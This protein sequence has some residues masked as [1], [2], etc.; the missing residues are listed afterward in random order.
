M[1]EALRIANMFSDASEFIWDLIKTNRD[2]HVAR[3]ACRSVGFCPHEQLDAASDR[4]LEGHRQDVLPI[5]V[6]ACQNP[7]SARKARSHI[8]SGFDW[9]IKAFQWITFALAV[10]A[11][12]F[13]RDHPMTV[14]E[15]AIQEAID[16]IRARATVIVRDAAAVS[17]ALSELTT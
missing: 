15:R 10:Q 4:A 6:G 17:Q 7:K 14:A 5:M 3:A 1:V 9:F 16:G 13:F 8:R 2:S 11:V 12:Q